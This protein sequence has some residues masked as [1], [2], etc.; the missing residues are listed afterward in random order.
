MGIRSAVGPHFPKVE[1]EC[2]TKGVEVYR[3]EVKLQS[4]TDTAET[5]THLQIYGFSPKQGRELLDLLLG[6]VCFPR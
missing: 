5:I 6:L 2:F 3:K 4:L 1:L